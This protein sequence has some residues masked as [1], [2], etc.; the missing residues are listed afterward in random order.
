MYRVILCKIKQFFNSVAIT[1]GIVAFTPIL[2]EK[3]HQSTRHI[4][5][6]CANLKLLTIPTASSFEVDIIP[7]ITAQL[8]FYLAKKHS[9]NKKPK[10]ISLFQVAFTPNHPI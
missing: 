9:N 3:R 2:S 1:P 4:S 6:I 10:Q 7:S 5:F 8:T